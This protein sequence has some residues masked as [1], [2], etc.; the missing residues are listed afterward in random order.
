MPSKKKLIIVRSF[1]S[2]IKL[3]NESIILWKDYYE[4]KSDEEIYTYWS[5][6][7]FS[8]EICSNLKGFPLNEVRHYINKIMGEKFHNAIYLSRR[9]H[10]D[11]VNIIYEWLEGTDRLPCYKFKD[12]EEWAT[13]I[14]K[15][16][17]YMIPD[18]ELTIQ[19]LT[20]HIKIEDLYSC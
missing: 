20:K 6:W 14:L 17:K 15:I 12:E 7:D 2:T 1:A 9:D 16:Y 8:E 11:A 5:F 19:K 3:I 18:S 10:H 13:D 4:Y